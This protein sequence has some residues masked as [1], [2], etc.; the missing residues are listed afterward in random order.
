MFNIS[1]SH[2]VKPKNAS[3]S[4]TVLMNKSLDEV[5]EYANEPAFEVLENSKKVQAVH[6]KKNGTVMAIFHKAGSL[7]L[8]NKKLTA[9][10]GC[11]LILEKENSK[12]IIY[13]ASHDYKS[14]KI[15]ISV[16]DKETNISINKRPQKIVL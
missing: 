6:N 7:N 8:G 1:I 15:K 2:G 11:A 4:Y 10:K 3:Y 14:R 9:S 12:D 16:S 5:K 13:I